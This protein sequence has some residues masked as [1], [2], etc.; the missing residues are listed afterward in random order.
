[1]SDFPDMHDERQYL[2]VPAAPR[3]I[4]VERAS[5]SDAED[6]L[7]SLSGEP[8]G[9]ELVEQ[10]MYQLRCGRRVWMLLFNRDVTR[11]GAMDRLRRQKALLG[12]VALKNEADG[13]YVPGL[14]I[15]T[16][17]IS[18]SGTLDIAIDR[19]SG[20]PAFG[21]IAQM[22]G[23]GARFRI[24]ALARPGAAPVD[25]EGLFENGD[26]DIARA[27]CGVLVAGKREPVRG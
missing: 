16:S 23:D 5:A 13:G 15:M 25:V 6:C 7:R 18:G 4:H 9:I 20:T 11:P 24:R 8:L 19:T 3:S 1:M 10:P 26:I 27:V 2:E 21:G 17:P 22:T 14:L 12:V